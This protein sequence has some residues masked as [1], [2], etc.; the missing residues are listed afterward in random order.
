MPQPEPTREDRE[1][2]IELAGLS[3]FVTEEQITGVSQE[4]HER[5]LM[6]AEQFIERCGFDLKDSDQLG[7]EM[8]EI[9]QKMLAEAFLMIGLDEV[10]EAEL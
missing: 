5:A 9:V 10:M 4:T 8:G 6:L 7:F 1:F 2:L 3:L